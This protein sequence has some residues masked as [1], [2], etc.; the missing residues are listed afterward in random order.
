MRFEGTAAALGAGLAWGDSAMPVALRWF[1]EDG[2]YEDVVLAAPRA[3]K[4][5]RRDL[6]ALDMLRRGGLAV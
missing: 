6:A 3:A 5:F 1:V 2:P 4:Y